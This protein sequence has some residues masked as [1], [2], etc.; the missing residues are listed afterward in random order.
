MFSLV[1]CSF[2]SFIHV[3]IGLYIC[4]FLVLMCFSEC[5]CE[6]VCVFYIL[7][8]CF[9]CCMDHAFE[10]SLLVKSSLFIWSYLLNI[11]TFLK[12]DRRLRHGMHFS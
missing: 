11:D 6:N 7:V 2:K 3:L 4:V 8:L 12:N 5:V 10:L 9:L 1:G